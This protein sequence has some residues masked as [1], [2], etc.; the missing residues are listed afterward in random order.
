MDQVAQQIKDSNRSPFFLD[1][2]IGLFSCSGTI[3]IQAI[4]NGS[5][6]GEAALNLLFQPDHLD[7]VGQAQAGDPIFVTKIR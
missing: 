7:Q 4:A 2:I 3:N 1:Q 6:A 5:Y